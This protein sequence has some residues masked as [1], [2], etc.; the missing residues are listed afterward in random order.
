MRPWWQPYRVV[1][2][3]LTLLVLGPSVLAQSGG[4]YDL[5]WSTVDGGGGRSIGGDYVVEGTIGQPDAGKLS[6]GGYSLVGGFWRG[7][8]VDTATPTRTPTALPT[9]TRTP[10][11]TTTGTASPTSTASATTAVTRTA[12]RAATTTPTPTGSAVPTGTPPATTT[13]TPIPPSVTPSV[14]VTRTLTPAATGTTTSATPTASAPPP[15]VTPT[16]TPT[17]SGFRLYLPHI[18]RGGM[19]P[20]R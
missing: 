7:A 4:G 9:L 18:N 13:A 10:G 20:S 6:G 1:M 14:T 16:G 5:A 17:E 3:L 12:T 8:V 15:T 11:P 2:L 19:E